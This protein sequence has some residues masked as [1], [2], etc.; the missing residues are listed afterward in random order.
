MYNSATSSGKAAHEDTSSLFSVTPTIVDVVILV[1]FLLKTHF[2]K[3][4]VGN[5]YLHP[6]M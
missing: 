5:V 2:S 3:G 4:P 1:V 6:V